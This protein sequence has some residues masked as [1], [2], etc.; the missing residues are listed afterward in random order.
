MPMMNRFTSF[1]KNNG[2]VSPGETIVLAVSGGMDSMVLLHLF[3]RIQQ[4]WQLRIIVVH[5][6]HL[7]RGHASDSDERFVIRH[8]RQSGF[9]MM[10]FHA[11]VQI[12][13]EQ[14]K[15]SIEEAAR[16]VRFDC[17]NQAARQ[18]GA[19]R[20]ALAHHLQDQAETMLMHLARGSGVRGL[21]GIKPGQNFIIHPLL[22]FTRGEI[23][24]WAVSEKIPYVTD[25]TNTD[26]RFVRNRIRQ[27]IIAPLIDHYGEE[28]LRQFGRSASIL[29]ETQDYLDHM[30]REAFDRLV[31]QLESGEIILDILPFL[32][33]FIIIRKMIIQEIIRRYGYRT[34]FQ[35]INRIMDL[36]A[37]GTQ[38]AKVYI[39]NSIQVLK[40]PDSLVFSRINP[41][42]QYY[43]AKVG[44]PCVC[45]G[46]GI[47]FHA[48]RVKDRTKIEVRNPDPN[49]EYID[50]DFIEGTLEIR[51]WKPGDWFIPFGMD[52]KKKI[53]DFFIDEK[54]P[55]YRRTNI[56]IV[57]CGGSVVWIAGYR[58][59]NRYKVH[60]HT[61]RI[62]QLMIEPIYKRGLHGK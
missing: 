3:S 12:L 36:I 38:G 39:Q 41:I 25:A 55:S 13:A 22:C 27:Y 19:D 14:N 9:P 62:L 8:V 17:L 20:I 15:L 10:S 31:T 44:K 21:G 32:H 5:V 23:E 57:T 52:H 28:V 7:L 54:I 30:T 61:S 11:N 42:F 34:T 46:F 58:L 16:L 6:N 56:P 26:T 43:T 53:H 29:Q 47:L 4:D 49:I 2:L 24:Q 45:D 59:D 37:H 60:D 40:Y 48:R 51:H 35:E 33:Y 1:L 50:S 18:T